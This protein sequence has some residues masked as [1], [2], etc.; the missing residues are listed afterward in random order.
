MDPAVKYWIENADALRCTGLEY[1]RFV[2][3]FFMDYWGMPHISSNLWPYTWA[4]D[5]LNGKPAIPGSGED[6]LSLTYSV[7][8]ARFV[9][10]SLDSENW[11]EY[12]IVVGDDVNFNQ[13][14]R[15]AE[16]VR[17]LKF[18][19]SYD[20]VEKLR[21]G[22]AT[23]LSDSYGGGGGASN[24]EAK[25]IVSLFGLMTNAGHF[26]MPSENRLNSKFPDLQPF[27][28][29]ELLNKAWAGR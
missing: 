29:E 21:N 8:V 28:A 13:L 12:S 24:E 17:G 26:H 22:E 18:D 20:S 5:V 14:L 4:I 27:T 9:V 10:R 7:D 2:N 3:G 6:I 23:L 19:V 15:L 25:T 1:T 16:K 11:P